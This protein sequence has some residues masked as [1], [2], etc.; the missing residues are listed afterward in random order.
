M[1]G[2][3]NRTKIHLGSCDHYMMV[4]NIAQVAFFLDSLLG[5][6]FRNIKSFVRVAY[7]IVLMGIYHILA[8]N[9]TDQ[10]YPRT[11][12]MIFTRFQVSTCF[13]YIFEQK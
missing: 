1:A 12:D 11:D 9:K 6:V 2:N 4:H 13:F 7:N 3:H 5:N 10:Q 8:C